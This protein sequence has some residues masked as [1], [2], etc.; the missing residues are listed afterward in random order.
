LGIDFTLKQ[1]E[2]EFKKKSLNLSPAD[3]FDRHIENQMKEGRFGNA[4]VFRCTLRILKLFDKKFEKMKFPDIDE[5]YIKR[6]D[7]FLRTERNLKETSISVYMRTL[8]ALLNAA[9]K[10]GLIQPGAYPFQTKTNPGY[11]ISDLNTETRKRFIPT[12]YLTALENYQFDDLRL[13]TARNLFLFSFYCRGMNWIDMAMLSPANLHKE[14]SES[15]EPI[16]VIKYNRAKT[17]KEYEITVNDDIQKLLDWFRVMPHSKK[18]LLPIVTVPENEGEALRLH[19]K[20]RL[21]KHNK[22]L[23]EIAK[24]E[25]LKFP[26]ALHSITSYFSRHSYAMALRKNGNSIEL[27]SESLGHSDLKT[28]SIYLDSFGREAVAKASENLLR[29]ENSN[30]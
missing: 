15:G 29:H 6:F 21:H 9:I 10:D 1:F 8:A 26:D 18:Y 16:T 20:E 13:E 4:D 12:K 23:V 28:T 25:E 3:Y 5:R 24:I 17:H 22:A 7:A 30:S 2:R 19:I 11:K 27:I 14:I